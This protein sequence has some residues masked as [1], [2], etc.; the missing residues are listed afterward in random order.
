MDATDT[1]SSPHFA[2]AG[3]IIDA[4]ATH[5]FTRFTDALDPDA[6]MIALVPRGLLECRGAGEI[7]A[8]FER[9][10]GDV[11]EYAVA[12]ASVGA[13]GA[14]LQLRWRLRLKGSRFGDEPMVVEQHAYAATGASGTIHR[15]SLLCSGFW[16]EHTEAGAAV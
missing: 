3:V 8:M 9:W 15:I 4:L 13:V 14:L 2:V 1:Q 12:D 5:E 16:P 11:D 7:C 6:Q 10:F